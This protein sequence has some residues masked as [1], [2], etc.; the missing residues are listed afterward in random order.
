MTT[1]PT[2]TVTRLQDILIPSKMVQEQQHKVPNSYSVPKGHAGKVV[3]EFVDKI[4]DT[5]PGFT[6]VFDEDSFYM[7]AGV[8]TLVVCLGAFIA[9]RYIKI[10][11]K[12]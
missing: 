2:S 6:D 3:M 7:F 5:T 9:S 4:Y 1:L 10:K 8:F 11:C 12:D